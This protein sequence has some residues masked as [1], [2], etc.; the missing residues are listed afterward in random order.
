MLMAGMFLFL[1]GCQKEEDVTSLVI[2][3]EITKEEIID[4]CDNI[5]HKNTSFRSRHRTPLNVLPDFSTL[6][7]STNQSG[8]SVYVGY[9]DKYSL[10]SIIK[11]T[12]D[13]GALIA[14]FK[15]SL[16]DIR[17]ELML[18]DKKPGS[19]FDQSYFLIYPQSK[20]TG[21]TLLINDYDRVEKI[22]A[23]KN[24]L[25][26]KFQN[27]TIQIS[28]TGVYDFKHLSP[29]CDCSNGCNLSWWCMI[30][31]DIKAVVWDGTGA[32][33]S[34]FGNWLSDGLKN[35]YYWWADGEWKGSSWS[36]DPGPGS[37]GFSGGFWGGT[38]GNG[39]GGHGGSTVSNTDDW[40]IER[41]KC[42]TQMFNDIENNGEDAGLQMPELC[43]VYQ[44]LEPLDDCSYK[45]LYCNQNT[46]IEV[47]SILLLNNNSELVKKQIKAA[48]G[49]LCASDCSVYFG[50][51]LKS[52]I[53]IEAFLAD[54]PNDNNAAQLAVEMKG[55]L[56]G[57]ASSPCL[58][59]VGT[60]NSTYGTNFTAIELYEI[61]GGFGNAC[62]DQEDFDEYVVSAIANKTTQWPNPIVYKLIWDYVKKK[63]NKR[64]SPYN[65][66]NQC[67]KTL[68][69]Q[70]PLCA[71]SIG[72]NWVTANL[73]TKIEMGQ[74]ISNECSDAF[75]HTIF[76][77]IECI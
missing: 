50:V 66:S 2:T 22:G 24:G 30:Y 77:C 46:T 58:T 16:G 49:S 8:H 3:R 32:V 64:N 40:Q 52:H 65:Q 36:G 5:S 44:L 63:W 67:E 4:F 47:K 34:D 23:Y 14:F 69:A 17:S 39:D 68:M 6:I 57:G 25:L 55:S 9:L 38:W 61:V 12:Q 51:Y 33:I 76:Q 45:Y 73:I 71:A 70:H 31:C 15:D 60:F 27:L 1:G 75:R 72:T 10:D 53:A 42:Y 11:P 59:A 54:H 19:Y 74:N 21:I 7:K 29:R 62:G 37:S 56:C 28:G 35:I 13:K 26:T 48:L 43:E 41:I 20:F 18:W